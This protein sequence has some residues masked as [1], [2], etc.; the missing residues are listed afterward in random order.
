MSAEDTCPFCE[1]TFTPGLGGATY[2]YCS[3]LCCEFAES[4]PDDPDQTPAALP[5]RVRELIAAINNAPDD[6]HTDRWVELH[7]DYDMSPNRLAQHTPRG[8]WHIRG[9]LRSEDV[10]QG[11]PQPMTEPEFRA[12]Y[13]DPDFTPE[14]FG[15]SSMGE[16]Q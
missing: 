9:V 7:C 2:F 3:E 16:V 14:Q 8:E 12:R 10:Y 13:E 1:A 5:D 11:T 6:D 4:Y 15:L